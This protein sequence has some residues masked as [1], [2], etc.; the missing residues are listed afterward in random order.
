MSF[1]LADGITLKNKFGA[2]THDALEASEHPVI[3]IRLIELRDGIG[4]EPTFDAAYLQALHKHLFQDVFEWA[5]HLRHETFTFE[6]GTQASMPAMH[7]VD[8]KDFAIG[9]AIDRGLQSVMSDL[10]SRDFLRGLDRDTFAN[11]AAESF[12]QLNSIHPFREGNGRTQREFFAALADRAGHPL[13]FGVIS[14]ERMTFV[15]VAAHERGDLAPMRRMFAEITDPERVNAL[16]VAQDFLERNLPKQASHVTAWDGIYMTTTEPGQD[17]SGR[18]VGAAGPNFM[19]RTDSDAIIIG[20]TVDL[21]TPRPE[22]SAQ[23]AF[24]ASD[25]R[26]PELAQDQSR[27]PLIAAVTEW[28]RSVEATVAARIEVRPSMKVATGRLEAAVAA[29]WQQPQ[30]V[31]APLARVPALAWRKEKGESSRALVAALHIR[32]APL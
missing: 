14:D 20:N 11:Q 3:A 19:M 12:A 2:E 21:P 13:E 5:G 22:T 1:T 23:F 7:K 29:V 18:F 25:P 28:P 31:L 6:D 17:Y 10:E 32:Q 8:G 4:P 16:G 9:N 30:A 15:S 24:T 27:A 26:A